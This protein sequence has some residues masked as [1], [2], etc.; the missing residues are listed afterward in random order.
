MFVPSAPRVSKMMVDIL[1]AL[2]KRSLITKSGIC[3]R[4]GWCCFG[5]RMI[6]PGVMLLSGMNAAILSFS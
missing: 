3:S 4:I 1:F 2:M 5:A 6:C